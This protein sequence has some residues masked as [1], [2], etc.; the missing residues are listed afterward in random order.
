MTTPVN[1]KQSK[2]RYQAALVCTTWSSLQATLQSFFSSMGSFLAEKQNNQWHL[3][4]VFLVMA[5][6]TTAFV[7]GKRLLV[8]NR[9]HSPLAILTDED[10]KDPKSNTKSRNGEH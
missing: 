10:L 8:L 4:N 6:H 3:K 2:L 7:D 5:T 9:Q 1:F